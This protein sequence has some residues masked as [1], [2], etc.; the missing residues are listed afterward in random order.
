M[1]VD[2]DWLV[3]IDIDFWVVLVCILDDIVVLMC[4]MVLCWDDL[5]YFDLILVMGIVEVLCGLL[6]CWYLG[7][8]VGGKLMYNLYWLV[9]IIDYGCI[10]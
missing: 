2:V 9:N 1:M 8:W 5:E 7:L 4:L 3:E 10:G 6:W